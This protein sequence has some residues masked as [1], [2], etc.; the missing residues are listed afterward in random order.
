MVVFYFEFFYVYVFCFLVFL[1]RLYVCVPRICLV[2]AERRRGCHTPL[3]LVA[4]VSCLV[5]AEK[6][7]TQVFWKNSQ[8]SNH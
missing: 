2:P 3:E 4:V 7:Q 6:N 5:D 8:C 1:S